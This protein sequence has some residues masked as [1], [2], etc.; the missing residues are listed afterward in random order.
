MYTKSATRLSFS[1]V[2][3]FVANTSLNLYKRMHFIQKTSFITHLKTPQ[4]RKRYLINI[5]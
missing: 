4:I 3:N 1:N 5:I 2:T